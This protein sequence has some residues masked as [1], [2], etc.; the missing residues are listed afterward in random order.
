MS[1]AFIVGLAFSPAKVVWMEPN[2]AKEARLSGV[3]EKSDV[4]T[5]AEAKIVRDLLVHS[6]ADVIAKMIAGDYLCGIARRMMD[7]YDGYTVVVQPVEPTT[8]AFRG[9]ARR[10][11]V[12]GYKVPSRELAQATGVAQDFLPTYMQFNQV[13]VARE[14]EFSAQEIW[15]RTAVYRDNMVDEELAHF[16]S[17]IETFDDRVDF[18]DLDTYYDSFVMHFRFK[19]PDTAPAVDYSCTAYILNLMNMDELKAQVVA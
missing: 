1:K 13:A 11:V 5:K 2:M 9:Q 7:S 4:F 19:T 14:A 8:Y 10:T 16:T 17:F 6:D 3:L 18:T 12:K 15:D